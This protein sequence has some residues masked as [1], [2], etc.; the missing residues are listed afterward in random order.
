MSEFKVNFGALDTAAA[1]ISSAGKALESRLN[2]LDQQ[3][4]PLRADWT[5]SASEAYAQSKAQWT[6]A[7]N[8]MNQLLN[9]IG[10]AVAQS[11]SGYQDM[12][13]SNSQ[14]WS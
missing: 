2:D 14:M 6:N 10:Q 11:G 3:L 5:G 12:E 7:I 13:K 9:D 4:S 8:D 1:D